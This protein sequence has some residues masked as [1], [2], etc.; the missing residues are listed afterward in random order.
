MGES[1]EEPESGPWVSCLSSI[2]LRAVGTLLGV[3][4]WWMVLQIDFDI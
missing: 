2:L 3:E 1:G 4:V